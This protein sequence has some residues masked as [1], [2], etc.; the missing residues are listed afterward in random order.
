MQC[1]PLHTSF[2]RATSALTS[3][4]SMARQWQQFWLQILVWTAAFCSWAVRCAYQQVQQLIRSIAFD[5]IINPQR[6]AGFAAHVR[7]ESPHMMRA[8]MLHS[9]HIAVAGS[10]PC[11]AWAKP[12][13]Y[14]FLKPA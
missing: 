13:L 4:T 5:K 8:T 3:P 1:V 12:S 2:S 7:N 11:D 14:R 6:L 10:M 9:C